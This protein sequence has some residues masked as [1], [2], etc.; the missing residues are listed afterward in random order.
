M[1]ASFFRMYAL[2]FVAILLVA[3][4][5]AIAN[6]LGAAPDE[7]A[8]VTT[9]YA[10]AHGDIGNV[11][12]TVPL[13]YSELGN[14]DSPTLFCFHAA[15]SVTADCQDWAEASAGPDVE[16]DTQFGT[17]N[18]VY[19]F[20]VGLPSLILEGQSA[21]YAMR[22]V[23]AVLF[24]ALAAA[25]VAILGTRSNGSL[26]AG[27]VVAAM[28]PTTFLL[29]GTVN[30]NAIEI[31]AALVAWAGMIALAD[32]D[33]TKRRS[34]LVI[35][36]T[37][38]GLV[39]LVITRLLSPLW[40]VAIVV[41]VLFATS[42]WSSLWQLATTS[43]RFQVHLGLVVVAGL[44]AVWWSLTNPA[45]FIAVQGPVESVREGVRETVTNLTVDFWERTF[46]EAVAILDMLSLPV[47]AAAVIF[48]AIW[49]GLLAVA[50]LVATS[51]RVRVVLLAIPI[52]AI[53]FPAALE[54]F[55][56]SG[57]GWQGRYSLPM[58]VGAPILSVLVIV[59]RAAGRYSAARMTRQGV[60]AASTI[61]LLMNAFAFT[62]NYQRF[63]GGWGATWN[64]INFAWQP[65]LG[66]I[67]WFLALL[68]GSALLVWL[69]RS[70]PGASP[71]ER[72]FPA[73][74]GRV[75]RF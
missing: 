21:L 45:K 36:V 12:P 18:P 39:V 69:V 33:M 30:V 31:A 9:A 50:V 44:Y 71:D 38:V 2:S 70:A 25:A 58:L 15:W 11:S 57:G 13:M 8:H 5:W 20:V 28:T 51:V 46:R 19:Y 48:A 68:A 7:G 47:Y 53:V 75:G 41:A 64:P 67:P 60:I 10:T 26:V 72:D 63:G 27:G 43:R 56:W 62:M 29:A 34:D 35:T 54:G 32:R 40:L 42:S 22:M 1:S 52:F 49:G 3:A 73:S 74:R 24:A 61:A 55:M 4:S 17:Y 66:P 37:T 6:P 59:N 14:R 65:P 23:S 16:A